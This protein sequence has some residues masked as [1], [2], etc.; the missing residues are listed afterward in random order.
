M[1]L[2]QPGAQQQTSSCYCSVR[3][4]RREAISLEGSGMSEATAPRTPRPRPRP[5]SRSSHFGS[6]TLQSAVAQQ[7]EAGE[8]RR[9]TGHSVNGILQGD[10]QAMPG[11]CHV[12]LRPGGIVVASCSLRDNAKASV[13][14]S[15]PL[16]PETPD[17]I[18]RRK[19]HP[20][21]LLLSDI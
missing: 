4:Q 14:R 15:Q 7:R 2:L 11:I 8:I 12:P 21:N 16:K 19:P 17:E 20:R 13:W 18:A 5:D 9:R 6:A 1:K 10:D 3:S